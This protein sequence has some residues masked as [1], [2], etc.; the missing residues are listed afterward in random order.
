MHSLNND[1]DDL[2][3]K[4]AKNYP[5]KTDNANWEEVMQKL[6]NAEHEH[7]GKNEKNKRFLWL[8]I[9][10][11][12]LIISSWLIFNNTQSS[13][14][15]S[16]S[17]INKENQNLP[18]NNHSEKAKM[19]STT[20]PNKQTFGGIN[21][22][23]NSENLENG[24]V[25]G[26][27]I[28]L[29]NSPKSIQQKEIYNNNLF[30]LPAQK[31]INNQNI[32]GNEIVR[33]Q[34]EISK[35]KVNKADTSVKH[36]LVEELVSNTSSL[37]DENLEIQLS[38][39]VTTETALSRKKEIAA[40]HNKIYIG[41]TGGPDVSM[42]KSTKTSDIGY[43]FGLFA[44]YKFS[45]KIAV[46]AGVLWDKKNYYSEGEHFKTERI[47]V[48]PHVEILNA[49]GM[50]NMFE[51]PLNLKYDFKTNDKSS[52]FLTGGVSSYLMKKEDYTYLY[53]H[54]SSTYDVYKE[55]NNSTNNWFSVVNFSVGYQHRFL[56]KNFLRV[57]PYAKLPLA[58]IGIGKLPISST[59]ILL[60]FTR[61]LR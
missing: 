17:E 34:S 41:L 57:E 37:Q 11:P 21:K 13:I 20:D 42:V 18:S 56:G 5:L 36:V 16:S 52:W 29:P 48:P 19:E 58:G 24:L 2:F 4:S 54:Y 3:K 47:S 14:N 10:L 59:G 39:P 35:E 51:I 45:K 50:C 31:N 6:H 30:E 25:I 23:L 33:I 40:K 15:D 55:Y 38:D 53:K 7:V 27:K 61:D 32:A 49:S 9:L 46:E 60:S 26:K 44:G 28:I 22:K 1:M 8:F 43:S 12:L